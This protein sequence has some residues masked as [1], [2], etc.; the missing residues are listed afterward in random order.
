MSQLFEEI[1]E[2]VRQE[3]IKFFFNKYKYVFTISVFFFFCVLMYFPI[4]DFYL[5]K[6]SENYVEIYFNLANLID[7]KNQKELIIQLDKFNKA[8]QEFLKVLYY[9]KLIEINQNNFDLTAKI[10]DEAIGKNFSQVYKDFFKIQKA[11]LFFDLIKNEKEFIK[12]ISL[13]DFKNSPWKLIAYEITGDF[14][15]SQKNF[16]KAKEVYFKILEEKNLNN[17]ILLE[18]I[19]IKYNLIN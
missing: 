1:K 6:K 10:I 3:K 4:K 17:S 18:N 19:K 15:V 7:K 14:Y 11:F 12:I 2:Q 9:I 13:P 8:D 5:K 16:I